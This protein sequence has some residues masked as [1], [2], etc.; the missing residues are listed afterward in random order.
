[1][2]PGP[3]RT[4]RPYRILTA[5]RGE[6]G[7]WISVDLRVARDDR[8]SLELS[9]S[10]DDPVEGISVVEGKRPRRPGMLVGYRQ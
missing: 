9:L 10:D 7:D 8:E 2:A 1:M 5:L 6:N 4:G 3:A